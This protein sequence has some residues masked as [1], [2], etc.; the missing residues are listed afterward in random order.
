MKRK[1]D[2][3]R[4][5]KFQ[6]SGNKIRRNWNKEKNLKADKERKNRMEEEEKKN[7]SLSDLNN[8]PV[9]HFSHPFFTPLSIHPTT[10]PFTYPFFTSQSLQST[11]PTNRQATSS[12][13][14]TFN[15]FLLVLFLNGF[16]RKEV[17]KKE[18]KKESSASLGRT[19]WVLYVV[20]VLV[21]SCSLVLLLMIMMILLMAMVTFKVK[22]TNSSTFI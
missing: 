20:K 4:N 22:I 18:R 21:H 11:P 19:S 13:H 17:G 14:T 5:V 1:D 6:C 9:F 7:N 15:L 8:S 16:G 10:T 12:H 2:K 3:R